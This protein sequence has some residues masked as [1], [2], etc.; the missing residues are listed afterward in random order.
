MPD[1]RY[2]PDGNCVP[3]LPLNEDQ[4]GAII[5]AVRAGRGRQPSRA[6]VRRVIDWIESVCVNVGMVQ[7]ILGGTM[8]ATFPSG[9]E[10]QVG[11]TT[12]GIAR[13]EAMIGSDR[14]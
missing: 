5:R 7:G 3:N 6:E 4:V 12:A 14:A 2:A 9:G 8:T 13:V 1:V 11:L 10:L